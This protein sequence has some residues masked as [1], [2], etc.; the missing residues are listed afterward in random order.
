MSCVIRG[1]GLAPL[2]SVIFAFLGDVVEYGQWKSHIRSESLVFA[3]GSFGAKIGSGIA[4]AIMTGLLQFVGYVSS[5]TGSAV[6]PQNVID[7]IVNVYMYGILIVW[8]IV[9]IGLYLYKLD[10]IYPKI[11]KDLVE[12]E[13]KGEL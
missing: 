5:D 12:R 3:G 6:Q 2:N 8:V 4:T 13:A 9:I 1:I 7:M 10:K 11:M